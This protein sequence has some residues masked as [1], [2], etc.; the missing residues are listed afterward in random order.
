MIHA[1][2]PTPTEE[3]PS[4][5]EGTLQGTDPRD[6]PS[7]AQRALLDWYSG[8]SHTVGRAELQ[9]AW[10]AL[11][12]V[13]GL[14]SSIDD[15][16]R[17][18]RNHRIHAGSNML[19][20]DT[21][22][23][24]RLVVT[25]RDL[26]FGSSETTPNLIV[27]FEGLDSSG[28]TTQASMLLKNLGPRL[29]AAIL[30]FPEYTSFFGREVLDRLHS[31]DGGA[32]ETDPRSMALWYAL[33]RWQSRR[34]ERFPLDIGVTIL[35]RYSLSN[36]VY[37]ASRCAPVDRKEMFD[38][39]LNLEHNVLELPWPDLTIFFDIDPQASLSRSA[40]RDPSD[41]RLSTPDVYER[42][43]TLQQNARALYLLAAEEDPSIHV[44]DGASDAKS[45]STRVLSLVEQA[46]S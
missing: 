30:S 4:G 22:E 25:S 36:A 21:T 10:A 26:D 23:L 43:L 38:W 17:E 33:D 19:G 27:A 39:V 24:V 3:Q 34:A 31:V 9:R 12:W 28:K 6:L 13:S 1:T 2:R 20:I 14:G 45:L 32:S 41:E 18:V 42:S 16:P 44:L 8:T 5:L 11:Q 29:P 46:L 7:S 40:R 15:L 37:Q 35:N